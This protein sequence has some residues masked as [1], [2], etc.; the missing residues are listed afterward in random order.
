MLQSP[1]VATD[2]TISVV[3]EE[4]VVG[5]LVYYACVRHIKDLYRSLTEKDF[6]Y[7]YDAETASYPI[8]FA[9]MLEHYK[10]KWNGQPFVPEPWQEFI[11]GAIFGWLQKSN[12]KRR[13]RYAYCQIGR[14]NGKTFVAAVI[15]LWML[16]MDGEGGAEVYSVANT[17]DQAKICWSD[18]ITFLKRNSD[19]WE[20]VTVRYNQI[21]VPETASKFVPAAAD[22]TNLD[23][24]NPHCVIYDEL[25][26]AE[27]RDLWDIF[28]D[29]FGARDQPLMLIITT[30]GFNKY[31]ICF[32][33]RRHCENVLEGAVTNLDYYDER[34]FAYIA[35]PD[36]KDDPYDATTWIKGNPNL[37]VSK[38]IEYVQ[39]QADKAKN[40]PSK[41]PSF[42]IKQLDRWVNVSNRWLNVNMWLDQKTIP[43]AKAA[44]HPCYAGL[45]MSTNIDVTCFLR[46]FSPGTVHP[47]KF[48]VLP[49]FYF[50]AE[51]LRD[52]VVRDKVPYDVWSN[53]GWLNFTQGNSVDTGHI[54]DDVLQFGHDTFISALGVDPWKATALVSDFESYGHQCFAVQQGYKAMT[55]PC[56]LLE[57]LI[58]ADMITSDGNPM[59]SWM[60]GNCCVSYDNNEN[61][62]PDKKNSNERIDGVSALLTA[63]AVYIEQEGSPPILTIA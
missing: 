48:Y 16:L 60:L 61:I 27:N 56:M 24:L 18:A 6:P 32:E 42:F 47:T 54:R 55:A 11:F 58:L 34:Y 31:S 25:H 28:E 41:E 52:R 46:L 51:N 49:K 37:G 13:F 2:Y 3:R 36:D 12:G 22:S 50:P 62:K 59:M 9:S 39:D 23:G 35:E 57:R 1:D 19:F 44:R 14:K 5:S 15:A 43:E 4:V 26:A 21:N 7:V 53:D 30:A 33:Q 38:S 10:G 45:D 63:L 40:M 8:A 17:R 29:A 20:M